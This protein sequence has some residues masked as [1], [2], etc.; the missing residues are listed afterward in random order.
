MT[1]KWNV[2]CEGVTQSTPVIGND[3]VYMCSNSGKLY[4]LAKTD[5]A[6]KV[7]LLNME[8]LALPFPLSEKTAPSIYAVKRPTVE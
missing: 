7:G 2:D 6:K 1:E 4:A 8:K 3:A 5:G